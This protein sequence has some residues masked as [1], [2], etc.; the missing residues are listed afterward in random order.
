MMMTNVIH[1]LPYPSIE[2]GNIS[3]PEGRYGVDVR[4][5]PNGTSIQITH[6]LENAPF[7][8]NLIKRERAQYGCLL[9]VPITGHRKLSL[10][11][12]PI[13][14]I[15]WDIG[16]IGE[17]PII[18]PIIVA[19]DSFEHEFSIA[20]GVAEILIGKKINIPKGARL[21]RGPYLRSESSLQSLLDIRQ[22]DELPDGCFTVSPIPDHG[23]RFEVQV[24]S[25]VHEFLSLNKGSQ[26]YQ[27]IG[28]HM[29]SMCFVIL[30]NDQ[31]YG[32]DDNGITREYGK[33]EEHSNL[34]ML[35]GLLEEK[36]L[37]H[38]SD[39]DF[40]PDEVAM[41]LHPLELPRTMEEE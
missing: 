11:S 4:S 29:V 13:H 32:E 8:E 15:E 38:W 26:L 18:R 27:S 2:A 31:G 16:I 10:C 5:L 40:K 21:A 24:A 23:F 39:D 22:N 25:D 20:D 35:S 34:R 30:Q 1:S 12:K 19:L 36:G 7:I 14:S 9:S 28:A 6:H 37:L 41:T 17:P 3:F 33:W